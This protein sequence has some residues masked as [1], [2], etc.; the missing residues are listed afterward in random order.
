MCHARCGDKREVLYP[1]PCVVLKCVLQVEKFLDEIEQCSLVL[2]DGN[3]PVETVDYVLQVC[4]TS[5]IPG[6][7]RQ[8]LINIRHFFE[9][10]AVVRLLE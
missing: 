3:I 4:K 7:E 1:T 6:R 2:V 9:T 5:R 10:V 8:C